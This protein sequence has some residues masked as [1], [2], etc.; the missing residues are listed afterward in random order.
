MSSQSPFTDST[1]VVSGGGR[2][3]GLAI[4]A[5]A[6]NRG[7]NVVPGTAHTAVAHVEA[8]GDKS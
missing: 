7:A 5:G 1:V 8:A 6:A 4:A 2:G 3:I